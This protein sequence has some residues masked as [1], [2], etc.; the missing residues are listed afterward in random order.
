MKAKEEAKDKGWYR[1][2][3]SG[4]LGEIR[5]GNLVLVKRN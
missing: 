3:M 2:S 5:D 4:K 1:R